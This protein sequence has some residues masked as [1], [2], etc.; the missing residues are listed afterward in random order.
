MIKN[1]KGGKLIGSGTEGCVFSPNIESKNYKPNLKYVSKLIGKASGLSEEDVQKKLQLQKIDPEMKHLNYPMSFENVEKINVTTDNINNCSIINQAEYKRNGQ[2]YLRDNFINIIMEYG[3]I[4]LDKYKEHSEEYKNKTNRLEMVLLRYIDIAYNI[5]VLNR[6]GIIHGDINDR[7]IVL[8]SDGKPRIIDFGFS[9]RLTDDLEFV[10]SDLPYL[11]KY[12]YWPVDIYVNMAIH[13]NN[14]NKVANN[15]DKVNNTYKML[16]KLL[17]KTMKD[18]PAKKF[19]KEMLASL[20]NYLTQLYVYE[21]YTLEESLLES[22]SKF[23]VFSYGIVLIEELYS[24]DLTI[25]TS[26]FKKVLHIALSAI[27]LNPFNRPTM[28]DIYERLKSIEMYGLKTISPRR[29]SPKKNKTF[30][31]SIL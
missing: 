3:G 21:K 2:N 28:K 17:I 14:M 8:G 29:S 26:L 20:H 10:I 1:Q 18:H 6:N 23:D 9:F 4:S 22:M 5:Y 24:F 16:S 11:E 13:Q 25:Q 15:Y 31:S 27:C 7:N 12:A 19:Q 30:T